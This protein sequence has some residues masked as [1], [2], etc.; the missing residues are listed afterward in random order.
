MDSQGVLSN[1][2]VGSSELVRL[3]HTLIAF[4]GV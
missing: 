3:R 2:S 1:Q 4:D